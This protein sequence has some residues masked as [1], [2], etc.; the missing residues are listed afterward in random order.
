MVT[1]SMYKDLVFD[2]KIPVDNVVMEFGLKLISDKGIY[3]NDDMMYSCKD[4]KFNT[5]FIYDENNK[6]LIA[7]VRNFFYSASSD[8]KIH[9][10]IHKNNDS[11]FNNDIMDLIDSEVVRLNTRLFNG[12][13]CKPEFIIS[14]GNEPN[15]GDTILLTCKHLGKVYTDRVFPRHDSY[16][17]YASIS[18]LMIDLYNRA[19]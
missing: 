5:I 6:E 10:H 4:G 16:Y 18:D 2:N 15:Y 19:M 9:R 8:E 12:D 14:I 11:R 1:L 13:M 7:R 17:G 3:E